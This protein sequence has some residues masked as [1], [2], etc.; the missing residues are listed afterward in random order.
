MQ[1]SLF[2]GVFVYPFLDNNYFSLLG[3]QAEKQ[4][5]SSGEFAIQNIF[6]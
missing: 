5:D 1:A 6:E 2:S 3:K 4:F